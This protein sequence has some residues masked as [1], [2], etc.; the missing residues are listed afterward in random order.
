DYVVIPH[1]TTYR[2]DFEPDVPPDLL[3]I[4]SAN[5]VVIPPRYLNPD[6]QIRLGAPF[7]ERDLHGPLETAVFDREQDTTVVIKDGNR[8]SRYTLAQHP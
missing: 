5:N 7:A 6:G 2:L 3:V 1:C 8:L 4:E